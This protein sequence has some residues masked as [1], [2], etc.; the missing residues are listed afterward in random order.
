VRAESPRFKNLWELTVLCTLREA[1]MHP[2]EILRV[3]KERHKEEVLV[4]KRGSLY[5]AIERLLAAGHI[6]E[7]D[8]RRQGRRP[9]RTTYRLTEAGERHLLDGLR[10]LVAVPRHEPSEFMAAMNFL[11][12]LGPREALAQLDARSRQIDVEIAATDEQ[13]GYALGRAG[14]VNLLESEYQQAMRRAELAWIRALAGDLRSG[15]LDWN[16]DA[17]LAYLREAHQR[18]AALAESAQ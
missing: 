11:V 5:H 8:T 13:I 16:L 14:R 15:R 10:S 12:H 18:R 7:L 9:E 2:Y 1:P 3:L 17:L 6:E 4:L